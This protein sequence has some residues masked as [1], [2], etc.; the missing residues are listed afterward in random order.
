ME[1]EESEAEEHGN[2]ENENSTDLKRILELK[3]KFKVIRATQQGVEIEGEN[4][5]AINAEI[6]S[7]E[8]KMAQRTT[9]IEFLDKHKKWNWV[10]YMNNTEISTVI[11]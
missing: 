5:D 11:F 7:L 8:K 10:C 1:R 6:S 4:E 9:R 3:E 2:L